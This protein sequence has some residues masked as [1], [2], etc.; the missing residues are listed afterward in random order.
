MNDGK[1]MGDEDE[2]IDDG[3]IDYLKK[4]REKVQREAENMRKATSDQG[5]IRM[6]D[7]FKKSFDNH[8]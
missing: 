5:Y 3:S 8:M 4:R 7:R 1:F 2:Y 6:V